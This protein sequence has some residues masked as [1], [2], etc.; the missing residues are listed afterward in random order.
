[1][2]GRV[3][4]PSRKG[5]QNYAAMKAARKFA[6]HNNRFP[7]PVRTIVCKCLFIVAAIIS[8]LAPV[9]AWAEPL[10]LADGLKI[11]TE[12]NRLVRIRQQEEKMSHADTLVARSR[13]LPRVSA[14]Y[15]QTFLE[16]QPGVIFDSA[17]APTAEKSYY[18]YQLMIQQILYDFGAA[19][20]LY[21]AAKLTEDTKRLEAKRTRNA[22]ALDFS[23]LYFDAL[24]SEKLII[25][26]ETEVGSLESH[27]QVATN[28]YHNGLITKNDLLQATVRLADAR[29]KLLTAQ[30]IRKINGARLNNMLTRPLSIPI[31]VVEVTRPY[32]DML[33]YEEA[34]DIA[35]KERPELQIADATLQALKYEETAKKSE[36]LPKFLIQGQ[37]DYTKN[38][39][40]T[41][42]DNTGLSVLMNLNLFNGG[43]T[44]AEV[45]K[46]QTAQSRLRIERKKL[47]DEIGLE[48]E[49]YYLDT[50]NARERIRVAKGAISQAEENLKITRLKYAEGVGIA[51]DVTDAIALRTLSETNYYRALYD[52]YRSEAG[53]LYAM[54]KNLKEKYGR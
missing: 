47:S 11:V 41:Y 27:V 49:K 36:Y 2:V 37:Y 3:L 35:E 31:E 26:A 25:V 8:C 20:S 4:N 40:L 38:K 23:V 7:S 51:T 53:Y 34:A 19:G 1:M 15:G 6:G 32:P 39:Y 13:L 18:T 9:A 43:S 12:E 48:L 24:E 21:Q 44:K 28:L 5:R 54:G 17:A 10:T 14:S 50:V 42:E 52:Y 33:P 46:V 22:V 16:H 30:N 45:Q 29:Q